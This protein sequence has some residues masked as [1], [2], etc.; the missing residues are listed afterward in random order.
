MNTVSEFEKALKFTNSTGS[1][2][3]VP[4]IINPLVPIFSKSNVPVELPELK[5]PKVKTI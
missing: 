5:A 1:T 4:L 3:S 2:V